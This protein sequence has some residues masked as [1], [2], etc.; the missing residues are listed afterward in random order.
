LL[1][2]LARVAA[3]FAELAGVVGRDSENAVALYHRG[4]LR[5]VEREDLFGALEDLD[6]AA[7]LDPDDP[8][9]RL[10][11]QELLLE[12]SELES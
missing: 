1:A 7:A 11:R 6:R 10:I 3:A 5:Y 9:V 2:N 12:R 4:L 8:S